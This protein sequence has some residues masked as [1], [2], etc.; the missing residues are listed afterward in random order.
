MY[1]DASS[2]SSENRAGGEGM[3]AAVPD[4]LVPNPG[5]RD[6]RLSLFAWD[7]YLQSNSPKTASARDREPLHSN[8]YYLGQTSDLWFR[9]RHYRVHDNSYPRNKRYRKEPALESAV[10]WSPQA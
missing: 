4:I 3:V 6:D 1:G 9:F 10:A 8:R 7:K 2:Y 5:K